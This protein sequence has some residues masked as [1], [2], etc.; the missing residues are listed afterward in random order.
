VPRPQGGVSPGNPGPAPRV[1][2]TAGVPVPA[3]NFSIDLVSRTRK[4]ESGSSFPFN[5]PQLGEMAHGDL[6]A[7]VTSDG[8]RLPL[9]AR[10][11][12]EWAVDNVVTDPAKPVTLNQAQQ[13]GNEPTVGSYRLTLKL[14]GVEVRTFTFRI[15]P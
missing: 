15:T 2:E 1:R 10:L 3:K 11:T 4:V 5:D 14:N 12:L 9:R 7:V 13:Y 6:F 8:Q